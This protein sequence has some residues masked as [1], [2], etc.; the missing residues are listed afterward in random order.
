[1]A[2][3]TDNA[4]L[5]T[6]IAIRRWLLERMDITEARVLDTC[7]GLGK[8]WTAMEEH[9]TVRQWTRC[10]VQPRRA[11]VLALDATTALQKFP[12]DVYNVIDIDPYGEPW[13]A[14]QVA[15]QRITQPTAVFL[16]RG[17]T[18]IS[19]ISILAATAAGIPEAWHGLLPKTPKLA[20]FV[21]D[22]FL[23]HT[24]RYLNI[25][26]A[27]ISR[28]QKSGGTSVTYYALGLFPKGH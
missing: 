23:S 2:V 5:D 26:H 28:I 13:P 17:H 8:I 3:K 12:L 10:D 7:C 6:K 18:G 20:D 14:Y 4:S 15:L 1:M 27:A 21:A 24:W 22:S 25:E 19:G 9:V 11:G 16:T